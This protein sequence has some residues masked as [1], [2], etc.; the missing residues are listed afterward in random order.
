MD[1]VRDGMQRATFRFAKRC[2]ADVGGIMF[3]AS[4]FF[5]VQP[6]RHVPDY[7]EPAHPDM[8][9]IRA[10]PDLLDALKD[11]VARCD[12]DEG[13]RP[14]GSNIQTMAAHAAILRAEGK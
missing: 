5:P 11:L 3:K 14:D 2:P 13:V 10:A 7:Q 6:G 8:R 1:A 4:E 12:G 9:L